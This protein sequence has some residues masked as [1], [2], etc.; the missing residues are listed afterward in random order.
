MHFFHCSINSLVLACEIL[1]FHFLTC[2]RWSSAKCTQ[3]TWFRS[4]G[5]VDR[6]ET[7]KDFVVPYS[8]YPLSCDLVTL[9]TASLRISLR[10][11]AHQCEFFWSHRGHELL[12]P[13]C[14]SSWILRPTFLGTTKRTVAVTPNVAVYQYT[15]SYGECCL[16]VQPLPILP[17][18]ASFRQ[19]HFLK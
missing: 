8:C 7:S 6:N 4:A 11:K 18:N 9:T 13:S 12:L 17:L 1:L 2:I 15:H 10:S 14:L 16:P 3:G 5:L 19:E